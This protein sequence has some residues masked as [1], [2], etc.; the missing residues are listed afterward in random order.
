MALAKGEYFWGK[1]QIEF[2]LEDNG[3]TADALFLD[4]RGM[5]ITDY[6]VNERENPLTDSSYF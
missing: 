2:D 6:R 5:K 3:E 1:I 4:F